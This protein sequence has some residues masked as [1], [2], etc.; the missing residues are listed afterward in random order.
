VSVTANNPPPVGTNIGSCG[1]NFSAT[2]I[3]D[4]TVPPNG[5][6]IKYHTD[7]TGTYRNNAPAGFGANEAIVIQFTA[8]PSEQFFTIGMVETGAQGTGAP[9]IRTMTLSTKPCDFTIP[10][11]P[12]ARWASEDSGFYLKLSALPGGTPSPYART[13]LIGGG[14]YYLNIK[15]S[16]FGGTAGCTSSRCDVIVTFSN[17]SP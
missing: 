2:K 8:P 9:S 7:V 13:S 15:N 1:N 5:S 11:G 12:D 17:S 3:I 14:T 16:A 4:A 10:Q 6:L